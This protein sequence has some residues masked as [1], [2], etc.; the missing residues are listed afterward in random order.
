METPT[1]RPAA[2]PKAIPQPT[3]GTRPFWEGTRAGELRIQRC[4]ACSRHFLYP[5]P[6]CPFCGSSDV[7]WVKA[8]GRGTL[9][10]YV[11]N[12]FAAPGFEGEVPY[13]IAVVQL[14]E[15]PRMLSNL[16]GVAA[17]PEAL[18]LDMP[19]EVTFEPRG[20]QS[21]PM[22]RPVGGAR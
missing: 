13:V 21:L 19:L 20:D 3:P 16:R 1:S 6:V 14:D 12:H 9:H 4:S 11:I 18:A 17:E 8:S 22:F 15:G 7:Q 5:R 10:S 2:K